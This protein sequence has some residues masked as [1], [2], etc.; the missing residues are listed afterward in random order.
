MICVNSKIFRYNIKKVMN[1]VTGDNMLFKKQK[2]N[3]KGLQLRRIH[4]YSSKILK[5][6]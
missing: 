1:N 3:N 2:K 6:W 4:R 5:N